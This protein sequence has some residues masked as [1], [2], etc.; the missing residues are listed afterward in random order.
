MS[1]LDG[2]RLEAA[3]LGLDLTDDDLQGVAKLLQQTRDGVR[4]LGPLPT[5]WLE[6]DYRFSPLEAAPREE[7]P[8]GEHSPSATNR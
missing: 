1:D 8:V 6:P 7:K 5:V 3:R 4:A 2:L